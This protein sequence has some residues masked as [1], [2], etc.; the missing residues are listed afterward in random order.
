MFL[1]VRRVVI[2]ESRINELY[3]L[4]QVASFSTWFLASMVSYITYDIHAIWEILCFKTK[5]GLF[6]KL[7]GMFA[8]SIL[9]KI[10]SIELHTW[11]IGMYFQVSAGFWLYRSENTKNQCRYLKKVN[12]R[13]FRVN[14]KVV[15][16]I[17]NP[18]SV[19]ASRNFFSRLPGSKS[20]GSLAAVELIQTVIKIESIFWYA[21]YCFSEIL[22]YS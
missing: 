3:E 4:L 7:G 18:S 20:C 10:S 8:D 13:C 5:C 12:L 16:T 21:M 15:G 19:F 1:S 22:R 6:A 9:Y 11:L 14:L 17:F 2:S